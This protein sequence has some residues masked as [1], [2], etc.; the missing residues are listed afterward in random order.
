MV[1]RHPDGTQTVYGHVNR[2]FVRSRREVRAG[3]EIAEVGNRG[4][5]TGPHLHFEVWDADGTKIN[6]V[7]WLR[8]H[9]IAS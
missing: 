8:T 3:E 7:P 1:L 5:S 6:P 4:H 2:V 9:G